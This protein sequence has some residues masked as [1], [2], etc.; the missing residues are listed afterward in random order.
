MK[1]FKLYSLG[2]LITLTGCSSVN[3]A[4]VDK[5]S[6]EEHQPVYPAMAVPLQPRIQYEVKI[7]KL[8]QLLNRQDISDEARAQ[9]LSERGNYYDALG[10]RD[11]AR[12]DFRNSLNINPAQPDVFNL[13]GIYFTQIG[14][15][16]TAYEAFDSTLELDPQNPQALFN[17]AVA[18]YYGGRTEL[19]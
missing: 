12:I 9:I 13:L 2:V 8:S 14:D 17:R 3:T 19:A 1:W 10:L 11:L 7:A 16:D 6:S 18:L 5:T 15:F 4:K